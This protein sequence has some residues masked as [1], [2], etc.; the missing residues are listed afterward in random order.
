MIWHMLLLTE[1]NFLGMFIARIS[2]GRTV[3]ELIVGLLLVP[4][5]LRFPGVRNKTNES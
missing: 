2:I 1:Q 3:R 4:F 5:R